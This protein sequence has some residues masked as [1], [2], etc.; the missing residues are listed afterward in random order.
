LFSFVGTGTTDPRRYEDAAEAF[1]QLRHLA[2]ASPHTLIQVFRQQLCDESEGSDFLY[3]HFGGDPLSFGF[4]ICTL[5]D[6]GLMAGW[7]LG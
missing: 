6:G 4:L 1:G 7:K 2:P 3:V 5:T